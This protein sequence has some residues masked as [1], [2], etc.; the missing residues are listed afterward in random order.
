MSAY[1]RL[2]PRLPRR[3]QLT[4]R[5]LY[6]RRQARTAFPR[7]PIEPLLVERRHSDLRAELERRGA[8]RI[9]TIASWPE[10]RRFAAILTHDVEGVAGVENVRRVIEIERRHGFR[11]S[12]NFVAEWYPI[13]A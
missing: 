10:G 11:S 4:L 3:L 8:E 9:P 12:W 6:A 7:W 13:E 1:Y 2:K 5:R